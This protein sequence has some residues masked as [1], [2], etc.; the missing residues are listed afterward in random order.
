MDDDGL[1]LVG[2]TDIS[3]GAEPGGDAAVYVYE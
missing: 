2:A 3:L 1:A